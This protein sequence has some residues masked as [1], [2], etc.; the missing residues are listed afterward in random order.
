[1]S[2]RAR[3]NKVIQSGKAVGISVLAHIDDK[4]A[5]YGD[6]NTGYGDEAT[7]KDPA[8]QGQ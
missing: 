8:Y 1:M 3:T 6:N 7:H 2:S 4:D 5:I